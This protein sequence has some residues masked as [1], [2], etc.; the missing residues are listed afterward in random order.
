MSPVLERQ[1]ISMFSTL[2][3]DFSNGFSKISS[4]G[5]DL[6]VWEKAKNRCHRRPELSNTSTTIQGLVIGV[7]EGLFRFLSD[8]LFLLL[9]SFLYLPEP[10][11]LGRG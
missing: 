10:Y 4:I 8:A 5:L 1:A 7:C 3:R 2:Q 9:W 6:Y 11:E